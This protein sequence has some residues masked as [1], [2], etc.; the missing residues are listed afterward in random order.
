MNATNTR[1]PVDRLSVAPPL[2]GLRPMA[3]ALPIGQ[4]RGDSDHH[5]VDPSRRYRTELAGD[6][7][8]GRLFDHRHP[9]ID[10]VHEDE[11]G[12]LHRERK[13]EEVLVPMSRGELAR[14]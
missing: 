10:V 9:T 13:R 8:D 2:R 5:A 7:A 12:A 11:A 1:E 4:M 6:G 14:L 3:G